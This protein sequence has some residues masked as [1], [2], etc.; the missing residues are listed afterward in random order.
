MI[1]LGINCGFVN[2]DCGRLTTSVIDFKRG[3]I[4]YPRPKNGIVRECP[5]WSETVDALDVAI[6]VRP[7]PKPDVNPDLVFVTKRGLSWHKETPD[8]PIADEFGKLVRGQDLHVRGRGFSHLRHTFL[9][10]G[11]GSLDIIATHHIMGHSD[12]KIAERYRE[13]VPADR[14]LTVTNHVHSWLFGDRKPS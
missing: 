11:E 4:T 3:W 7:T 6:K 5:L 13:G 8:S 14:L 9:T 1:L 12:G 2:A 10:V